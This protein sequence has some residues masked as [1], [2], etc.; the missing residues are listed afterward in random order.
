MFFPFLI[1]HNSFFRFSN[2]S[3]KNDD[4]I[5]TPNGKQ[6]AGIIIFVTGGGGIY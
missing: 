2:I 3:N 6:S 1:F 4:M 5:L